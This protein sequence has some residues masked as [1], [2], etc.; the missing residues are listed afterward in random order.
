M[1]A[2]L[3]T[4]KAPK[5]RNLAILFM[6]ALLLASCSSSSTPLPPSLS[7]AVT[8]KADVGGYELNYICVGEGS[9]T[10]I[11]EAG[12]G[13]DTSVWELTM[14]YYQ[15]YTRICAYDRANLGK[16]DHAPTPRTY[17]DM[18]RDLHALLQ[19]IPIEG[20]Y[21]L[22][23]FSM[24]GILVQLYAGEFPE[25]IVGVVLVDSF[26]PDAGGRLASLLPPETPGEDEGLA[27][28]REYATWSQVSDGRSKFDPEDVNNLV[29]MEQARAVKSLGD[30]PLAVISRNPDNPDIMPGMPTLPDDINTKVMLAW[31]ELQTEFEG[32]STNSTRYIA[33]RSNHGIPSY[34]PRL[35]V[36]AI[37]HVVDE[38]RD[39]AGVVVPPIE[40]QVDAASHIPAITGIRESQKW[41]SGILTIYEEISY[42]DPAGD[43][44]TILNQPISAP[45]TAGWMDDIILATAAEQQQGTVLTTRVARCRKP[46]EVIL[47]Y[48]V[49]DS[50]GNMSN[51]ERVSFS[52]PAPRFYISPWLIAGIVFSLVLVGLGIR[53]LVRH[54]R[55][56]RASVT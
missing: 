20:P 54:Q 30:I 53:L 52:C 15:R 23:G 6:L 4:H 21:V 11:L 33:V 24:G 27:L 19:N 29:S 51:P 25:D 35:V 45:I 31:Q 36:E 1:N 55:R 49:F 18:T 42:T 50:A 34:E 7:D 56:R 14:L 48:R 12:N 47:E 32:L 10:V 26:H 44:L 41:E 8:G 37:R 9:P 2:H 16:S 43:A 46:A 22:A 39:Q 3:H 40:E 38:Y 13:N 5:S 17:E 28:W